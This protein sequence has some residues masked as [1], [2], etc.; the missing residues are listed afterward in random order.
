VQE[1]E[2]GEVFDHADP[3]LWK[4]KRA[5]ED[6][7]EAVDTPFAC[8]LRAPPGDS[9]RIPPLASRIDGQGMD[10]GF[11]RLAEVRLNAEPRF[12]ET[13]AKLSHFERYVARKDEDWTYNPTWL[14]IC[15]DNPHEAVAALQAYLFR[16]NFSFEKAKEVGYD[17]HDLAGIAQQVRDHK[18]YDTVLA[19]ACF[20][21]DP[22]SSTGK[23]KGLS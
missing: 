9:I 14:E 20:K 11:K 13:V 1:L 2:D 3:S 18:V 19:I 23:P 10:A 8:P 22:Q 4:R 7:R 17:F 21:P 5:D 16:S 12:A 6:F 15:D